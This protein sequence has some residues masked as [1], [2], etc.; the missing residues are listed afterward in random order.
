MATRTLRTPSILLV[1]NSVDEREL[2]TRALNG[3]G[4]EVVKA[5]TTVLAYRI[6]TTTSTDMVITVAHC[7][8]S[9]SG[10]E[11]T[12]RLRLHTRTTTV[13]IIALTTETRRQDGELSI[14]AGADMFL[15][16]PVSGDVLREHVVRLLVNSGRLSHQSSHHQHERV[17]FVRGATNRQRLQGVSSSQTRTPISPV[18]VS[19]SNGNVDGSVGGN[20]HPIHDRTCPQCRRLLEYRQKWPV[21]SAVEPDRREPRDR[22]R[23]VS[24]W[25]CSDRACEYQ[26]LGQSRE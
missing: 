15:E 1:N 11:L 2:Y 9:M 25:F 4:Y 5:A 16:R 22:L 6:A 23:Y 10:L 8:G 24:G 7:A 14:K 13:P 26:E 17:S 12:R 19:R 21:L 20:A 18:L 3:C